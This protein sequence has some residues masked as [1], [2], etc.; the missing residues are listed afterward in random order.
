MQNGHRQWLG[1]NAVVLQAQGPSASGVRV[2]ITIYSDGSILVP[3]SSYAGQNTG[4]PVQR[5]ATAAFRR[6]AD[7]LFGFS[8]SERQARTPPGWL[9]P[10]RVDPVVTFSLEIAAAYA[11]A[12]RSNVPVSTAETETGNTPFEGDNTSAM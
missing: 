3:F 10:E 11:E 7:A 2:V 12:N 4:I 5:L 9:T 8:G 6:K 1:S